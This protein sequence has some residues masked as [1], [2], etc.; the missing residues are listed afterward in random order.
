MTGWAGDRWNCLTESD[1]NER[2]HGKILLFGEYTVITGSQAL[3]IPLRNFSG[4]LRVPAGGGDN[5]AAAASN[6]ELVR[7][8]TYLA[9]GR[10]P[11]AS[12]SRRSCFMSS[13]R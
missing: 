1:M 11:R 10:Q 13:P 9:G 6:R 4:C 3:V 2:F 12:R 8:F 5:P 7:F